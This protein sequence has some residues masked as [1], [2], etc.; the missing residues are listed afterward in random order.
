MGDSEGPRNE[1]QRQADRAVEIARDIER[2]AAVT[3]VDVGRPAAA[4]GG[5]GMAAVATPTPTGG[6]GAGT[7]NQI[8]ELT[9]LAASQQDMLAQMVKILAAEAA[10]SRKWYRNP[11]LMAVLGAI[12]GV[13]ATV[14][15]VL[16]Q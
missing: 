8:D 1:L 15:V 9:K 14:A 5:R 6:G 12:V 11:L 13:G 3:N 7:G 2:L 10:E 16:A 4:A